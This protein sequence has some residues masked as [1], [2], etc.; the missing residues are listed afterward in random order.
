MLRRKLFLKGSIFVLFLLNYDFERKFS[1][2]VFIQLEIDKA[3]GMKIFKK[4]IVEGLL[5]D[6]LTSE[7]WMDH[8]FVQT[9]LYIFSTLH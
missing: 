7:C 9:S 5:K 1:L 6:L 8:R 2:C 4:N 3:K